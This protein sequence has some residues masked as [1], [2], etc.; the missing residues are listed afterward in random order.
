MITSLNLKNI[1]CQIKKKKKKELLEQVRKDQKELAWQS[2][3]C[4][5]KND[6]RCF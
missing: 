4:K 2:H 3:N 6:R 1:L 5:G